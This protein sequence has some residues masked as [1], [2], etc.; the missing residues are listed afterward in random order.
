MNGGGGSQ[1]EDCPDAKPEEGAACEGIQGT[2]CRYD[3]E[4]CRCRNSEP[5]WTCA[6]GNGNGNGFPG[7]PGGGGGFPPGGFPG[8]G[9]FPPGGGGGN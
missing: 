7:G 3:N 2:M 6:Q 9:G 5:V 4:T 8:G 1:D